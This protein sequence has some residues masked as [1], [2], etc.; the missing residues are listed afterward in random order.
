MTPISVVIPVYNAPEEL[1]RCLASVYSTVPD[2][3]EV[4]VIDDA[5][6]DPSTQTVLN[7]WRE[8]MPASWKFHANQKNRGFVAT[9]NLGMR[10]TQNDIVLLNSDTEPTPG[11]LRG[12]QKCLSS[13]PLIATATPWTN[14]GEIASIPRFCQV[15]P[16]PPDASAVARVIALTGSA[17]YPELP[18]AVGFCMA[19]ARS[20]IDSIGLFDEDLFGKG[21]GEENDFSMRAVQAGMRNVLCDDVYIVH[22]GGRSFGPT[23][24]KPDES[25]M[26]RLLSRHPDYLLQ[27]Q[28]FITADPLAPRRTSILDALDRAGVPMG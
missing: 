23:G 3:T 4:V 5:S 12:L 24:L 18:T 22:L 28:K 15:N 19:I 26:Q 14:N 2:D 21:Y 27:V 16:V 11:W 8:V 7:R 17:I 1:E 20:S 25:S 10:L 9:A 6:P 13:D